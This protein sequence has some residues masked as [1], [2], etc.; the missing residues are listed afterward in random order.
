MYNILI[1]IGIK[2]LMKEF[3]WKIQLSFALSQPRTPNVWIWS[4]RYCRKRQVASHLRVEFRDR[5]FRDREL[6]RIVT[7]L[8]ASRIAPITHVPIGAIAGRAVRVYSTAV[9]AHAVACGLSS[10]RL[11]LQ[12]SCRRMRNTR[13]PMRRAAE[14]AI[15]TAVAG[16]CNAMGWDGNGNGGGAL[17]ATNLCWNL[18]RT[19][20][21]TSRGPVGLST[22]AWNQI[23]L[24]CIRSLFGRRRPS[25]HYSTLLLS[26]LLYSTLLHFGIGDAARRGAARRDSAR[27]DADGMRIASKDPSLENEKEEFI[28]LYFSLLLKLIPKSIWMTS[29][30]DSARYAKYFSFSASAIDALCIL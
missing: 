10:G 17:R 30:S 16:L 24:F 2:V 21:L 14:M 19:R 23:R 20:C 6:A 26:P 7:I 12:N 18:T 5:E 3:E 8:L 27:R 9:G 29:N 28:V 1:V 25:L 11:S 4:T 15:A 13:G 22:V